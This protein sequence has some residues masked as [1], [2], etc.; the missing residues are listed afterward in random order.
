MSKS[1]SSQYDEY[2]QRS[3]TTKTVARMNKHLGLGSCAVLFS[4]GLITI[5]C[6]DSAMS[7]RDA[8]PT[9]SERLSK[10]A[11]TGQLLRTDGDDLLIREDG[12]KE[13][14]VHVDDRTKMDAGR[15]S[16]SLHYRE[17]LRDYR[18]A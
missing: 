6:S 8:S 17:R 16:Q 5:G 15:S 13:V 14:R 9:M 1:V 7:R 3:I 4:L 12:G 18:S 10:E 11:V 2:E